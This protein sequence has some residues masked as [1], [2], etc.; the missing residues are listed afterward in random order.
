MKT[1]LLFGGASLSLLASTTLV[2][3][4]ER[5]RSVRTSSTTTTSTETVEFEMEIDGEPVD[6]PFGG[7]GGGSTEE[8]SVVTVD[9]VLETEDGAPISVRRFF[10]EIEGTRTFEARDEEMVIERE[11]PLEDVVLEVS[12]DDA[13]V[14]EGEEPDHEGALE[15]V[16]H[17]TLATSAETRHPQNAPALIDKHNYRWIHAYM[18]SL[19]SGDESNVYESLQ[20]IHNIVRSSVHYEDIHGNLQIVE[21]IY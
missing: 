12:V 2:T 8:R 17:S 20:Y 11:A 15:G 3:D 16:R 6:S 10:E 9:R 14:V 1:F 19:V 18:S 21:N 13:E 7:A 5:E 4:Y